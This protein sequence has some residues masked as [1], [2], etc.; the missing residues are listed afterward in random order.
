VRSPARS[1]VR[2][3]SPECLSPEFIAAYVQRVLADEENARAERHLQSCDACLNE[4]TDAFRISASLTAAEREPIPAMLKVRVASLWENPAAEEKTVPFSR[5]VIRV[6]QQGLKLLAQ[7]LTPPLLD[8]QEVL[9]PLPAYRAGEGSSAL[10]LKINAGQ[11]E[12]RATAV[13]EREG[14][15]LSLTLLGAGQQTLGGQRVFLRRHGRSVFSAKTDHAGVLRMPLLEA[16]IYEVACPGIQ[17][18]FQLELHS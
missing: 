4:V 11:A 6:A 8:V 5:L 3:A 10:N 15:I 1:L 7:H 12:I 2:A 17:T 14:V 9:A 16:G 18:T 13:Q